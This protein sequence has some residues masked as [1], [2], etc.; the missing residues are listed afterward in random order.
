MARYNTTK[1]ADVLYSWFVKKKF[2][3]CG[4][5]FRIGYPSIIESG[6]R[7]EVGNDVRI[8]CHSWLN[9]IESGGNRVSLRLG[10]GCRIGRFGHV[11]AYRDVVLE[12][13]VLIADRVHISDVS[14]GYYNSKIPIILQPVDRCEPV[15]IETGA[16]IGTGAVI[17]PGVTV[18]K[19]AVVGANAVVSK[20]VPNNSVARGNPAKTFEKKSASEKG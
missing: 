19:N 3:G 8:G 7:I 6:H 17:L 2:H 20:D 1:I 18:G 16:W 13:Y 15:R 14:H 5:S 9:C 4:R 12:D 11:N 10:N